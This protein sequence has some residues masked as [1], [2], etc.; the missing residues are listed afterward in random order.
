MTAVA[1]EKQIIPSHDEPDRLF[2][3]ELLIVNE[4]KEMLNECKRKNGNTDMIFLRY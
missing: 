2:I 3:G 1:R 4:R